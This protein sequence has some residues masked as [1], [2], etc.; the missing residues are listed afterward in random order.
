MCSSIVVGHNR[1]YVR[2]VT[3]V[4]VLGELT[5]H[6]GIATAPSCD[7][8]ALVAVRAHSDYPFCTK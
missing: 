1:T 4:G 8:K 7:A 3:K 6:A 5:S 2:N